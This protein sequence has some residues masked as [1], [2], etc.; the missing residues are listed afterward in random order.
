MCGYLC[1]RVS[2]YS[3]VCVGMYVC[4]YVSRCVCMCV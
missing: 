2:E 3:G 4:G 1:V